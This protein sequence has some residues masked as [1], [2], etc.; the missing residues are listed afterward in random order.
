MKITFIGTGSAFSLKN[1]QTNAIITLDNGYRLLVDC[2]GDV[3][4]AL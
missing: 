2:G 1:F 3:R 4:R